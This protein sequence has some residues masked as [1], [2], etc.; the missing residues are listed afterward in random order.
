MLKNK[1][2]VFYTIV[3]KYGKIFRC[4]HNEFSVYIFTG[5]VPQTQWETPEGW[6][7]AGKAFLGD[8]GTRE[9]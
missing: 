5:L 8:L 4:G 1:I 3:Y 9:Q 2:I 6:G 7:P